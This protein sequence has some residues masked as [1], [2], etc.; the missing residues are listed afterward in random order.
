MAKKNV[1]M[2]P[3]DAAKKAKMAKEDLARF[4]EPRASTRQLVRKNTRG[5]K[6]TLDEKIFGVSR[7]MGN[8]T[9][10]KA[11]KVMQARREGDLTRSASRTK[12]IA[13]REAAK[14][15]AKRQ[16]RSLGN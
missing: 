6:L 7:G 9:E 3:K 13:A 4:K 2:S 5:G 12:G 8:K 15:K 14:T 11:A 10:A 16:S 1:P